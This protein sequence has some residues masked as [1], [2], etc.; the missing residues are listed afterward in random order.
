ML[1]VAIHL[2]LIHNGLMQLRHYI[3]KHGL[4][5]SA[6][7][8]LLNPPVS[9]GKVNHWIQGTRRVS[10]EEALQIEQITG[11]EVTPRDLLETTRKQ[12]PALDHKAQGAINIE[13]QEIAHA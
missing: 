10:L 6:F 9:Q 11:G 8:Q 1:F 2:G 3:Q 7:G 4:T 13:A 5:Q 12:P